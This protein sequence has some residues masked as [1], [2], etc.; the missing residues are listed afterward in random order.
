MAEVSM[1]D[2]RVQ[3]SKAQTHPTISIAGTVCTFVFLIVVIF[4]I[5]AKEQM[6]IASYISGALAAMGVCLALIATW[7]PNGNKQ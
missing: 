6:M 4:A 2:G 5:F 3:I 7:R 1:S